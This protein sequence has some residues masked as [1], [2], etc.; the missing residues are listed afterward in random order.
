MLNLLPQPA[1]IHLT[2]KWFCRKKNVKK[3]VVPEWKSEEYGLEITD[4]EILLKYSDPAGLRFAQ[5]TLK[6]IQ[7]QYPEQL[8]TL[9]IHDAPAFPKRGVMLDVSRGND[10]VYGTLEIQS[11]S[12][13]F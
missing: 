9:K 8:P 13:V 3:I 4:H 6:Q 11:A 1:E 2:G 7:K 5:Q 10:P 12:T